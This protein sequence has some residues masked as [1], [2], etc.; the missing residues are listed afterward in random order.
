MT[1]KTIDAILNNFPILETTRCRLRPFREDDLDMLYE[2]FSDEITMQYYSFEA[3]KNKE[4]AKNI[5]DDCLK[6][7]EE[8]R[9]LRWCIADIN[10]DD[11]I[12]TCGFTNI[13]SNSN[14]ADLG[15]LLRKSLWRQGI[16]SEVLKSVIRY[17]FEEIKFNRI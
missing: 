11:M 12:G 10:S 9:I 4:E 8:K 5:S 1:S 16:M 14:M 7:L 15:Y 2:I 3:F 13:Y 17:G 6:E